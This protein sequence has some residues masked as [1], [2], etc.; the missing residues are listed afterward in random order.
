MDLV[1]KMATIP[2]GRGGPMPSDV[3]NTPIVIKHATVV[4]AAK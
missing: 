4:N 3:P 2:T 1:D